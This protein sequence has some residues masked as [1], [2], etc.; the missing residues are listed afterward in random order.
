[1]RRVPRIG[2]YGRQERHRRPP[3]TL[4][5]C[6]P[7]ELRT[8][9]YP[10]G[11]VCSRT[12][13]QWPHHVKAIPSMRNVHARSGSPGDTNFKRNL[14]WNTVLPKARGFASPPN[15]TVRRCFG[16]NDLS[17]PPSFAD[18]EVFDRIDLGWDSMIKEPGSTPRHQPPFAD[19]PATVGLVIRQGCRAARARQPAVPTP[20]P[21]D[22]SG[23]SD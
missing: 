20:R 18:S 15:A 23:P 14:K 7:Q 16:S 13:G 4:R 8:T 11:S 3:S 19:P 22:A 1:V 6:G 5:S 21:H 2:R 10:I 9:Y 12:R 17:I